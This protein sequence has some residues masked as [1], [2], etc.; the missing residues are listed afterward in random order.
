MNF[1]IHS[2]LNNLKIKKNS[3][4]ETFVNLKDLKKAFFFEKKNK[5]KKN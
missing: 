1:L 2:R 5:Y 4:F 3:W